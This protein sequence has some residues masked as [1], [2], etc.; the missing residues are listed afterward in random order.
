MVH[1]SMAQ[2]VVV[3][4]NHDILNFKFN[5]LIVAKVWGIVTSHSSEVKQIDSVVRWVL[6]QYGGRVML[7]GSSAGAP[8]AGSAM[9]E[10]DS[11]IGSVVVGYPFGM[12][13]SIA[14]SGHFKNIKNSTKPKYFIMGAKDEFTSLSTFE[15]IVNKCTNA[16]GLIYDDVGHFEL[17]SPAFDSTIA[18]NVLSFATEIL[19]NQNIETS[20]Q[21]VDGQPHA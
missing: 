16:K 8:F 19:D 5:A 6:Q 4:K 15:N 11:I 12:W 10:S 3:R 9:D 21:T 14:F 2:S 1:V 20:I 18:N 7:F 17:E 13:A